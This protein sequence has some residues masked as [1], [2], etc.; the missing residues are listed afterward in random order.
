MQSRLSKISFFAVILS[1]FFYG[2]ASQGSPT[3]G[4]RDEQPPRILLSAPADETVNFKGNEILIY[5]DEWIEQ[6]QLNQELQIT[7][8]LAGDFEYEIRKN[9]LILTF[10]EPFEEN[11]TYTLNFGEGIQDI[12]ERNKAQNLRLAF[13]TGPYI[14]SLSVQGNVVFG[15][16]NK[17]AEGITVGL[18]VVG[19]TSDIDVSR[20]YYL[21][22]TDTSGNFKIE[23][24]KAGRYVL[25]GLADGNRNFFFDQTGESVAFM[26]DT[27]TLYREN[28][29]GLDLKLYTYDIDTL[30]IRNTRAKK[31]YFEVTFSKLFK[32]F[33]YSFEAD[34]LDTLVYGINAG[35]VIRFFNKSQ[36]KIDSFP[37]SLQV[38]DSINNQI[39][40]TI[41]AYFN[42][43]SERDKRKQEDMSISVEPTSG[44]DLPK[45]T[46][47]KVT[48]QFSKPVVSVQTDSISF[49]QDADTVDTPF[50]GELKWLENYTKAEFTLNVDFEEKYVLSLKKGAFISVEGDTLAPQEISYTAAGEEAF[51]IIRGNVISTKYDKFIVQVLNSQFKIEAELKTDKSFEFKNLLPGK[52]MIRVLVDA[53]KNGKWEQGDIRTRTLPEP[54]FFHVFEKELKEN[55]EYEQD[56]TITD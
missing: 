27:L 49:K 6:K 39:D 22:S 45:E 19:D 11:T 37:L 12:T 8:Y 28:I 51:S 18:Y 15:L 48:F 29:S 38:V 9:A 40:T 25:Y 53:N 4:P 47:Q 50:T 2:C 30:T 23:N 14:D 3:G 34:S 13:S 54:V 35:D 36:Q 1:F 33:T 16:K 24:I 44:L 10:D 55:W 7:P 21:A 56:I 43:A 31:Q 46:T 32:S 42:E 17:K 20:P 5:F 41:T 52:K 26:E